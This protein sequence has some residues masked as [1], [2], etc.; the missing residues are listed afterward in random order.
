MNR[1][2]VPSLR[3]RV[4]LALMLAF[5][6]VG[7]VLSLR[8][9]V[10]ATDPI[11]IDRVVADFGRGVMAQ[12]DS[13]DDR[14]EARGAVESLEF[15]INR[16]YR[17]AGVASTLAL[18]LWDRDGILVHASTQPLPPLQD[19][20]VGSRRI[21]MQGRVFHVFIAKD[22]RWRIVVAQPA[23]RRA[24]L[25]MSIATDLGVSMLIAFPFVL[26]PLWLIVS[27]GLRP[28]N[29]LSQ[30]IAAR[31][32][33]D[34]T[35]TGVGTRLAELQPLVRSIDALLARLRAKVAREHAF[36]HDAAHE[37]RTPM[38]VIS[39]QAHALAHGRDASARESARARLDDAIARASNLIEQLLQLARLDAHTCSPRAMD[40]AQVTQEE[41]AMLEPRAFAKRLEL[42]LEAPDEL[43][44]PVELAAFRA[45]LQNLVGNAIRYVPAGGHIVV[46]LGSD[47]DTLH[48]SVTDDG[49]GIDSELRDT[50]FDRFVRGT[51]HEIPGSGLGLPIV[52]QAAARLQGG[53]RL[54]QGMPNTAG[55]F[56]CR[57]EVALAQ[58][59]RRRSRRETPAVRGRHPDPQ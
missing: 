21:E 16:S 48:L 34:L 36:V 45:I 12:L 33:D 50:V 11:E 4:V 56:G 8:N 30:R 3:L 46:G 24:W 59:R 47:G 37:L 53:V 19:A 32:P 58:P 25:M 41:L 52:R 43:V 1:L 54:V 35:E 55:T 29:Q 23:L 18:Q 26:L 22:A 15:Q 7:V 20:A 27:H 31:D 9:Y 49:P 14:A 10:S 42:S 5:C 38:A 2:L 6:M 40:V 51:G 57:F 39:A 17:D 13:I 44:W 28:L